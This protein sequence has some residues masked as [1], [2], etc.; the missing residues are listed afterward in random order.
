[1]PSGEKLSKTMQK[2]QRQSKLDTQEFVTTGV[3]ARVCT[4]VILKS[5]SFYQ[6][7]RVYNYT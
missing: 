1:M 7:S 4:I 2:M 3:C 6:N 5:G